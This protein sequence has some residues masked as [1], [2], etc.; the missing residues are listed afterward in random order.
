[1]KEMYKKENI[2]GR[3]HYRNEKNMKENQRKRNAE[4]EKKIIKKVVYVKVKL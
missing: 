3:K 1:M 4:K 2:K